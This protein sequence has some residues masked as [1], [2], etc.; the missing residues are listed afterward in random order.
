M[1]KAPEPRSTPRHTEKEPTFTVII[2]GERFPLWF[3]EASARDDN[4]LSKVYADGGINALTAAIGAG[5]GLKEIA[6]LVWLSR[7]QNGEPKLP[8]DAVLD[9]INLESKF[10]VEVA[11]DE[12]APEA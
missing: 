6:A 10:E 4:D 5:I 3:S 8:Y 1:A 7:R 11:E 12:P 9:S 2:D